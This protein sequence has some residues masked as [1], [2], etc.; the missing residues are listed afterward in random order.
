M[1]RRQRGKLFIAVRGSVTLANWISNLTLYSPVLGANELSYYS[2]FNLI[3]E[4]IETRFHAGFLEII[5]FTENASRLGQR[6]LNNSFIPL[7]NRIR[8][9][10]D[11]QRSV[12]NEIIF[13]GHSL[14]GAIASILYYLYQNDSNRI[15]K[16]VAHARAITFGSP[17][18]VLRG[19]EDGYNSSC[20][21]LFR[22]WNYKDIVPYTPLYDPIDNFGFLAGFIHV[23]RALC[24]DKPS[25]KTTNIN[26]YTTDIIKQNEP[27]KIALRGS[28]IEDGKKMRDLITSKPYQ[29]GLIGSL[30][31]AF[32][33]VEMKEGI[34][35]NVVYS[36]ESNLKSN[37]EQN[38]SWV[39]KCD[40]L[41]QCGFEDYLKQQPI[42]EDPT[43]QNYSVLGIFG[44]VFRE[45]T[46]D[47]HN[48]DKYIE[49]IDNIISKEV[50]EN[51][52]FLYR[53]ELEDDETE[54]ILKAKEEILK[55]KEK[56]IEEELKIESDEVMGF[57]LETIKE[58]ELLVISF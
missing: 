7:Y 42:G 21:N 10:I 34:G 32:G 13:T 3:N 54:E 57:T 6:T 20:P 29:Q 15:E 16:K 35:E 22:C 36:M 23:G 17:R 56:D 5:T 1:I 4:K 53:D 11:N 40:V 49:N 48:I 27:L 58:D 51:T 41:G 14:G 2:Q 9:E 46:V 24:L 43:Q 55:P 52:S 28:N 26:E 33:N 39:S 38:A 19:Y 8:R 50:E 12:V 18:F 25:R 31:T 44:S 30:L 37:V 45:L 47:A